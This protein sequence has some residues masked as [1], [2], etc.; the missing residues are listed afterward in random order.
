MSGWR[1]RREKISLSEP[2]RSDS[3]ASLTVKKARYQPKA[4]TCSGTF[5]SKGSASPA[6]SRGR[7]PAETSRSKASSTRN[8]TRRP[9]SPATRSRVARGNCS[10]ATAGSASQKTAGVP[11][12][13]TRI[14]GAAGVGFSPRSG[15]NW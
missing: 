13:S 6:K 11:A 2:S 10:V 12:S 9:L 3:R 15:T 7:A 14:G 1:L 8:L 5:N 4:G